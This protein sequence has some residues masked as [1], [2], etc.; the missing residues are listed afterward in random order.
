MRLIRSQICVLLMDTQGTFDNFSS[1]KD[2]ASIFSI[3]AFL[4]SIQVYN[5]KSNLE[6]TDLEYL[7]VF[8]QYKKITEK[9]FNKPFQ[10]EVYF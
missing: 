7:N 6:R 10:F 1:Q 9:I 2:C 8:S 3:S 5:L 4:S